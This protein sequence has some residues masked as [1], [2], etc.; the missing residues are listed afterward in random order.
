M[1]IDGQ[2]M[3]IAEAVVATG[4]Q[5]KS[6]EEVRCD[7]YLQAYISKGRAPEPVPQEPADEFV[8]KTLNLPP[9][10]KPIMLPFIPTGGPPPPLNPLTASSTIPAS[11]FSV[12]ASG[13]TT[14]KPRI[15]DPKQLPAAQVFTMTQG[16]PAPSGASGEKYYAI[17]AM[18][19]FAFF[20]IEELRYYAYL[21]GNKTPSAEVVP[22]P[23][24]AETGPVAGPITVKVEGETMENVS[25]RPGYDKHSP[26]E[27][28]VAYLLYGREMTSAELTAVQ[29]PVA[30]PVATASLTAPRP[31]PTTSLFGAPVPVPA[32]IAAPAPPAAPTLSSTPSSGMFTF[33]FRPR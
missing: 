12:T 30:A 20:S 10:F 3:S 8:R 17:S 29:N 13:S 11:L 5:N 6:F 21:T 19:E 31:A 18:P 32:P 7:D 2:F 1:S 4:P 28:R 9:L 26:E 15:T 14:G 27:F 24:M 33:G 22:Q 16:P 23:F 25:A